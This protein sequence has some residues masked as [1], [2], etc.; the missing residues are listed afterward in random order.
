M[1]GNTNLPL[2]E[3]YAQAYRDE[4][5]AEAERERLIQRT[6][7]KKSY[8]DLLICRALARLGREMVVWGLVLRYRFSHVEGL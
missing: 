6:R 7:T 4:R 5:M 2:M 3:C 8:P 1:F